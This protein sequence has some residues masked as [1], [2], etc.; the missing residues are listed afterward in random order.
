MPPTIGRGGRTAGGNHMTTDF[1]PLAFSVVRVLTT[2]FCSECNNNNIYLI[3]TEVEYCLKCP[4]KK[5]IE[6]VMKP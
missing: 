3:N 5:A 1:Q 4:V 6:G 2:L